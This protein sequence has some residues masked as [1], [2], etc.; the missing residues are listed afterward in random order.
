MGLKLADV[1]K[2]LVNTA[3]VGCGNRSFVA[4]RPLTKHARLIAVGF[5]DFGQK[6]VVGVVGML[7]HN[8]KVGVLA[9]LHGVLG[10]PIFLVAAHFGVSAVLP[11]HETR[12]RRCAHRCSGIGLSEAHTLGSHAVDV[13]CEDVGLSIAAQIAIAH[14]VAH[15]VE[16]V[17]LRGF[18]GLR[19]QQG[20]PCCR[21]EPK[22]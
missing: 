6:D 5:H 22:R 12:P 10:I 15:D 21:R 13:G 2:E 17:G 11:C 7:P 18:C 16:D 9:I 8:G 20:K 1:A 19:R 3:L 4:A 14:V